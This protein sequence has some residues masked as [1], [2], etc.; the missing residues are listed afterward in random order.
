VTAPARNLLYAQ[1]GF[2]ACLGGCVALDRRGLW[3]NHGWSYYGGRSQTAFIYA[4]GFVL[5]IVFVVRG[6]ALLDRPSAPAAFA[7]ALR[8][9]ALLLAV[10]LATPDTVN[11]FF[12][13]VHIAASA[14]LFLFEFLFA[15]WIVGNPFPTRL[16][17]ALLALQ[18]A[19]G[20][21][22]MFSQLQAL[23]LLGGG[24]LLF[25]VSFG[26]LLVAATA[27]ASPVEIEPVPVAAAAGE[28]RAGG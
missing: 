9:L 28:A 8:V 10:D 19:G 4:A 1:L 2:F 22:A 13:D 6:V 25:Q 20:L 17:R 11:A 24:I 5:C 7:Q 14:V 21:L 15:V 26:A 23:S 16:G 27:H 3:D 12:Y 18:L